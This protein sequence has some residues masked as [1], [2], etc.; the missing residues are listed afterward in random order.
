MKKNEVKIGE[1]Y[2]A[3]VSGGETEVRIT[4]ECEHGGWWGINLRT[5]RQIRL[6]T[7]RRLCGLAHP[8]RDLVAEAKEIFTKLLEREEER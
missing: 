4:E 7:G 1:T 3:K 5:G 6:R 8:S 2:T